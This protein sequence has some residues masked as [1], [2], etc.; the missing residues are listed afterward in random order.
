MHGY[1]HWYTMT[2]ATNAGVTVAWQW[3]NTADFALSL[4]IISRL[5]CY[6]TGT[7]E[8]KFTYFQEKGGYNFTW[9]TQG[10]ED[11]F[12]GG[13]IEGWGGG[14]LCKQ[15]CN[16]LSFAEKKKK[17]ASSLVSFLLLGC[18][19]RKPDRQS[20]KQKHR[21][22]IKNLRNFPTTILPFLG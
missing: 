12:R 15:I 11:H 18:P 14:Q 22:M 19:G 6:V 8:A 20:L 2:N 13:V 21:R 3:K 4:S 5:Q 10:E 7:R 16:T 17:R 9:M 1:V